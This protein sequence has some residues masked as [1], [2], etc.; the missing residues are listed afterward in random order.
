MKRTIR[1]AFTTHTLHC[2]CVYIGVSTEVGVKK[3]RSFFP[4][5][6]QSH[7]QS[8][9]A[10]NW[11]RNRLKIP[12]I[13]GGGRKRAKTSAWS[14]KKLLKPAQSHSK[15]KKCLCPQA[16]YL[17]TSEKF[18]LFTSWLSLSLC[19]LSW[20]D[21]LDLLVFIWAGK[22]LKPTLSTFLSQ[23]PTYHTH[24]PDNSKRPFEPFK[25]NIL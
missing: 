7:C 3:G 23:P 11:P 18:V 20:P 25:L 5:C 4:N 2:V 16:K 22:V 24:F 10:D 14:A 8:S 13:K 6:A 12:Y 1:L 15:P 21:S 17:P 19:A 9:K